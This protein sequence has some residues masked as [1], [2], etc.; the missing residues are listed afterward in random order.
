MV[1]K[2]IQEI[3]DIFN[4][5][6]SEKN[7]TIP[8][9]AFRTFY[10]VEKLKVLHP[11]EIAKEL[12]INR[13]SVYHCLKNYEEQ[14]KTKLFK[15]YLKKDKFILDEWHSE[16]KEKRKEHYKTSK[17]NDVLSKFVEATRTIPKKYKT[18]SNL[19]LA[20]FLRLNKNLNHNC[21]NTPV[22]N[23]SHNQ[24]QEIRKINKKMFDLI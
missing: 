14:T 7:R 16:Y 6:L 18:L 21:W 12:N 9:V 2:N 19:K 5:D 17:A 20:E 1:Y 22:I 15:A 23:I 13:T 24:W 4:M 3:K 8:Y 11:T 10:V